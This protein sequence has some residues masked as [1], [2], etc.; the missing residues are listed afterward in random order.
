MNELVL[1][2]LEDGL[3]PIEIANR[4][5]VSYDIVHAIARESG[6][7]Y[8]GRHLLADEKTMLTK[9]RELE[10][11]PIRAIAKIT[12]IPKTT[13]PHSDSN[14]TFWNVWKLRVSKDAIAG[15]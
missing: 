11:L 5:S 9:L 4:L 6:I 2:M 12:G 1:R 10:G 7:R 3:R 14:G 8:P 13:I 15:L